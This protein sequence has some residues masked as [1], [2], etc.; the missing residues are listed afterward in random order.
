MNAQV[1]MDVAAMLAALCL[2]YG[3]FGSLS[4][5]RSRRC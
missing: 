1:G 5:F 4:P 2:P 3:S